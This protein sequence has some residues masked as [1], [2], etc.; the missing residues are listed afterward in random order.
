MALS[1]R[2]GAYAL[3]GII[4]YVL[5]PASWWNDAVVNIPLALAIAEILEAPRRG[6]KHLKGRY[7]CYWRRRIGDYRIVYRVSDKERIVAVVEI[8]YRS[9]CY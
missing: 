6:D 7:H 1:L 9:Q 2:R 4:G 5:S 8:C 3:A